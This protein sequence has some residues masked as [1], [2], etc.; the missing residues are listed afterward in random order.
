M[1]ISSI[2]KYRL[3]IALAIIFHIIGL[4][5]IGIIHSPLMIHATP[6]HLLLM[7]T[8]LLLSYEKQQQYILWVLIVFISGFLVEVTGVHTG[9]LFGSY[10]YGNV[11]GIKMYEVPLLIG[12]NWVLVLTGTI[13]IANKVYTNKW[14]S[15]LIAAA[16]ATLYD[17]LL[18]PVAVKLGFWKWEDDIVPV[19]NYICWFGISLLFAAIW[20][21]LNV[22]S[23]RFSIVLLLIQALFFIVLRWL[24]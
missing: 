19:Y 13:A 4:V 6:Y 18:E 10:S 5:G 12:V 16:M 23:N 20:Q 9:L 11:L 1:Q 21:L 14:F 22:K 24:L 8:L 7:F 15:P 17:W 2:V 3:L